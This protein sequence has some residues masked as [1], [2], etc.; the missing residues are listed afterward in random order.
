MTQRRTVDPRVSGRP[1]LLRPAKKPWLNVGC[2]FL[3]IK[4]ADNADRNPDCQPDLCFDMTGPWPIESETYGWVA[5][6][7][8]LEHLPDALHVIGEAWRVLKPDGKMDILVPHWLH[9]ASI[10]DPTHIRCF[11]HQSQ[12][13]WN[14]GVYYRSTS[15]YTKDRFNFE[16]EDTEMARDEKTEEYARLVSGLKHGRDPA[17]KLLA[18]LADNALLPG[19]YHRIAFHLRKVA[20][21][22]EPEPTIHVIDFD[23]LKE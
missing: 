18:H 13:Y 1:Q 2:G 12:I 6:L 22:P 19:Y 9:P 3:H 21:L 20:L 5:M 7:D 10:E 4:G 23:L 16:F 8:V 14:A 17:T 15:W 11:S